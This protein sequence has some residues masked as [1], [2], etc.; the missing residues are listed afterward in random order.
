MEALES[1]QQSLDVAQTELKEAEIGLIEAKHRTD[2]AREGA[3]RLRAAVAALRGEVASQPSRLKPDNSNIAVL[4]DQNVHE[5]LASPERQAQADLTPEEFDK[6]RK[7]RQ[8]VKQKALDA[9]NPFAQVK[10]SGCGVIGKMSQQTIQAPSGAPV[11]M[12]ICGGC[13]NQSIG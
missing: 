10:C 8:R 3:D 9:D 1:V 13:G 2:K 6:E 12:M 5:T 7:R 4:I 11:R